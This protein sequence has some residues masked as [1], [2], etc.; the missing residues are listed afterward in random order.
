MIEYIK[1]LKDV[2]ITFTL[3]GILDFFNN[4]SFPVASVII[5]L[6]VLMAVQGYKIFKS[7]VH[8]I[9]AVGLGFAGHLYIA[10]HVVGYIQ[11]HVPESWMLDVSVVIALLCALFGVLLGHIRYD[12]VVFSLGGVVGFATGYYFLGKKIA[13][14]F[15]NISFLNNWIA[16]VVVGIVLGLMLA[17]LFLLLFKQI[18]II[19]SSLGCMALASYLL[20]KEVLPGQN[21]YIAFGFIAVGVVIGVFMM[22][23]QFEEEEKTQEF[24]F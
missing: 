24:N 17:I 1:A 10:P 20:F 15:Y 21:I 4:L 11:P 3:D 13:E 12:F 7:V 14:Y 2:D 19:G 8:V 6:L 23:H 22:M 16:H 5:G 9:A 18:Y